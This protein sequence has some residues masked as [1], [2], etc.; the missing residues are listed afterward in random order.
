V[1]F[2]ETLERRMSDIT[3]E[4]VKDSMIDWLDELSGVNSQEKV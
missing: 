1:S 2:K 4:L 3:K